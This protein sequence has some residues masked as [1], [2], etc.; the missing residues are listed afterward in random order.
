[1]KFKIFQKKK[2]GEIFFDVKFQIDIDGI[3]T[4][5]AVMRDDPSKKNWKVIKNDNIGLSANELNH[6]KIIQN[7]D[8]KKDLEDFKENNNL[9]KR[10]KKLHQL[11]EDTVQFK[12]KMQ[13]LKNFC[14][15]MSEF[16]DTFEL[17]NLDNETVFE[18]YYLYLQGLFESYNIYFSKLDKEDK[19][20]NKEILKKIC[21]YFSKIL[22]IDS[23]YIKNL[24]DK[25]KGINS[26]MFYEIVIHV[27]GIMTKKGST[28][29]KSKRKWAKYE[30]KYIFNDVLNINSTY[31]NEC[32]LSLLND[33]TLYNKWI[34]YIKE[35]KESIQ[36]INSST[37]IKFEE[38]RDDQKL[39]IKNKNEDEEH[40]ELVLDNFRDSL[41]ELENDE[42]NS[43]LEL[44]AFC[45][46]NIAKIKYKYL[47]HQNNISILKDIHSIS[48]KS[49]KRAMM[50]INKKNKNIEN[51]KWFKEI[52]QIDSEIQKY[53]LSEEKKD[54]REYEIHKILD[55]Y[56]D[57]HEKM[58]SSICIIKKTNGTGTGFFCKINAPNSNNF[59]NTLITNNHILNYDDISNSNIIE[60]SLKNKNYILP[61][62]KPRL[63]YFNN[64][65]DITIIEILKD[66]NLPINYLQVND[67]I[68][69]N[70]F[71]INSQVYFTNSL[72]NKFYLGKILKTN[73]NQF[74]YS[75]ENYEGNPGSPIM[76]LKNNKVIGI[77]RGN[78]KNQGN[79]GTFIK[80]IIEQFY[81]H[82]KKDNSVNN[83]NNK[84]FYIICKK[85]L[86]FP[87][88]EFKN[89][90]RINIICNNCKKNICGDIKFIFDNF[91]VF[92]DEKE[93]NKI[94]FQKFLECK[95]HQK[96]FEFYCNNCIQ[97]LCKY[98]FHRNIHKNHTL[99]IFDAIK[100]ETEMK[101]KNIENN[102]NTKDLDENKFSEILNNMNQNNL[103]KQ[104]LFFIKIL[105]KFII[106][107]YENYPSYNFIKTI[108]NIYQF[109]FYINDEINDTNKSISPE[110]IKILNI[111]DINDNLKNIELIKII[112][113]TCQNLYNISIICEADLK[114][115]DILELNNNN[116]V[117][118]SSFANSRF[119]NLKFLNLSN[120][121]IDDKNISFF[122]KFNFKKL[123]F[124]DLSSNHLENYDLF[125]KIKY[126]PSL[127][128]LYVSSNKFNKEI[129]K[130]KN[131]KIIDLSQLFEI[132]LCDGV[133]SDDSIKI[134]SRFKLEN[135]KILFLNENKLTSI[136]FLENLECNNLEEIWINHN[137]IEKYESLMKFKNLKRIELKNNSIKDI[138]YLNDFIKEFKDLKKLNIKEN[139]FDLNDK[140]N[141]EILE[142]I[143]NR[144]EIK[145]IYDNF[146]D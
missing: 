135:L 111:K 49:I 31:L 80:A 44:E 117:D 58:S 57:F 70:N 33:I 105:I 15:V 16:I 9:K 65:L 124:F 134:I 110:E 60:I 122:E 131:N 10:M 86:K 136:K 120:N 2:S 35:C 21:N 81:N 145:I 108:E 28:I 88:F 84:D 75:C 3:L 119:N 46:A 133:F 37:K 140:K 92:K 85:C 30:A 61:L 20:F 72:N 54:N 83:L 24:L 97:N 34:E 41:R 50:F 17:Y 32:N 141:K 139:N 103:P 89:K 13:Y 128:T 129:D 18:K 112:S 19:I 23:Y 66:D 104:I 144:N 27:M 53:L 56:H 47:N 118:I 52:K 127:R 146:F 95:E 5:S 14:K 62:N 51:A 67:E 143:K 90:Y 8:S 22:V 7:Y 39:Y 100:L 116:I 73:E 71:Y 138:S 43:D 63:K 76:Y 113:I 45:L 94:N 130:N 82:N 12:K 77:H 93:Y 79:I 11:Y 137:K 68:M 36:I 64:N 26:G 142:S 4:V 99:L 48:S 87:I 121:Q 29:L 55:L 125:K 78:S 126:F 91:F 115:L 132:G 6:R 25:L 69:K 59:L 1:M 123:F 98:C 101:I 114:N 107:N 38:K 106:N 40:L 74:Y 96:K 42:Q 109:L 102:L